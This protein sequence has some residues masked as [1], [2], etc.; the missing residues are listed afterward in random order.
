M[1]SNVWAETNELNFCFWCSE[2]SCH[3][4]SFVCLFVINSDS[5]LFMCVHLSV[6]YY[7]FDITWKH[8]FFCLAFH[9][10]WKYFVLTGYILSVPL[11]FSV[12]LHFVKLVL[13]PKMGL[14]YVIFI[15]NSILDFFFL[16]LF[17]YLFIYL[18]IFFFFFLLFFTD[19]KI[20]AVPW[21][22]DIE[23]I[24]EILNKFWTSGTCWKPASKL[25]TL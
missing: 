15:V 22:N 13:R 3:L 24:T 25:P 2:Y 5:V 7:P 6:Y 8:I 12:F 21:H 16:F 10:K 18:F 19:F 9:S 20:I 11:A 1:H 14:T 4:C 23:K 17:F